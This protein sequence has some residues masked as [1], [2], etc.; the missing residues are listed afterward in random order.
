MTEI[1]AATAFLLGLMGSAHC[2]GMCGGIGAALGIADPRRSFLFAVCYN[3]GR[4]LC[5]ALLG[6]LAA[7]FVALLGAGQHHVLLMLGPWLRATAGLLVVAMGL[8]IGGWWFGL[9]R[10][11]ALGA[12]VWR[13][14]QP[15]TRALLPPRH[16]GAALILG[17]LWGLLPCGLIYSSL[18][19][20]A[21]SGEPARGALLMGLFGLGTWPALLLAHI[22]GA[23]LRRRLQQP[24]VR[25]AAGM[26]LVVLGLISASW[27]WLHAGDAT[28]A[29][30]AAHHTL[31]E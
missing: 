4:V 28:H 1:S 2:L 13:R 17:A 21:L 3:L 29:H 14:V 5:Y 16:A 27:P 30:H 22:G 20:A 23:R 10:L 25:R 8:Y 6:A 7:G 19:W 18:S 9:G 15:F 12:G 31:S 11:E 26:T 24:Q